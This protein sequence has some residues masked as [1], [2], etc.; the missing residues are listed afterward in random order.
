MD[1]NPPVLRAKIPRALPQRSDVK[2]LIMFYEKVALTMSNDK[3]HILIKIFYLRKK[4]LN[5][6]DSVCTEFGPFR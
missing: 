6:V 4:D 5:F 1:D 2:S 3:E